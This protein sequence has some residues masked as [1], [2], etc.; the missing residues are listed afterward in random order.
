MM[1]RFR[2]A[3]RQPFVLLAG[4]V[5]GAAL[6]QAGCVSKKYLKA[7]KGTPPPQLLNVA[8]APAPLEAVLNT[9]VTYNGPGS[10]KR[11]AFWDEF[12]VT[13][14]NT[15]DRPL[16]ITA[17]TV[18]DQTGRILAVG[19]QPWALEKASK[20]QEQRY[21]EAG[22]AFVRYT[23]PAVV[24]STV[25]FAAAMS[26]LSFAGTSAG[27]ATVSSAAV[28]ALPLYYLGVASINHSNKKDMTLQFK[29]R[30]LALPLSLAPG[31]KRSGSFF[32]PVTVSPRQLNLRWSAGQESTESSLPLPFLADLHL[33]TAPGVIR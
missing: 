23:T 20:T 17:V 12:V 4:L 22:I 13:L 15:S 18:Q 11:D 14:H 27:A 24:I 31:E 21:K 2:T 9:V 16:V 32:F 6:L 3:F 7:K 26:S 29:L 30:N 25:G 33:K 19:D 28:V 10:W 5:A 1:P 8:F